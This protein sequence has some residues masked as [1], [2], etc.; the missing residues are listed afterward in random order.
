M[1]ESNKENVE[2]RGSQIVQSRDD[3]RSAKL[4]EKH[5]RRID[6]FDSNP[7]E[8]RG[9]M[10]NLEVALGQVDKELSCLVRDIIRRDD[11]QRFPDS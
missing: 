8:L 5:V 1:L 4:E 9:W 10:F 6:K 3:T 11:I 7:K 2:K